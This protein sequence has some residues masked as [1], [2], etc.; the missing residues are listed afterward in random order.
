MAMTEQQA[1]LPKRINFLI[2]GQEATALPGES[3]IAAADRIGV[4]IPRFCYHEKLSVVANCRQCLVE[5][6]GAPKTLPACATKVTEGMEVYTRSMAARSSQKAIMEFL[7][8]NHPLDCPICDQGGEC[9]LQD[10]AMGFGHG[11]SRFSEKKRAVIDQDLGPLVDTHMTRCIHCTRCI[12]FSDELAGQPELAMLSRGED[13]YVGTVLNKGL[14]SELSGNVI[15]VCPVGA[16]T[17]KPFQY[18]GRSWAFKQHAFASMHDCLGSHIYYQTLAKGYEGRSTIMR[19]LPKRNDLVNEVWLADRDRFSYQGLTSKE[20]L[21]QPMLKKNGVFQAV[22]WDEALKVMVDQMKTQDPSQA[23]VL[24]SPSTS[25]E[26]GFA[27]KQLLSQW[28]CD[29]VDHRLQSVECLKANSGVFATKAHGQ[30]SDWSEVRCGLLLGSHLRHEQPMAAYWL[31][32]A[33][34][35]GGRLFAANPINY[36]WSFE[37]AGQSTVLGHEMMGWMSLAVNVLCER[38]KKPRPSHLKVNPLESKSIRATVDAFVDAWCA[39]PERGLIVL[40]AYALS[41]DEASNLIALVEL[42][43]TLAEGGQWVGMWPGANALGLTALGLLP[44]ASSK[45]SQQHKHGNADDQGRWYWCHQVEPEFDCAQGQ[46]MIDR[47]KKADFVVVSTSY[48]SAQHLAYADC[49]LPSCLPVEADGSLM[50]SFGHQ[51]MNHAILRPEGQSKPLWLMAQLIGQR[52]GFTAVTE[53]SFEALVAACDQALST[54]SDVTHTEAINQ[55]SSITNITES[56]HKPIETNQLYRVGGPWIYGIDG[57]VR[58]AQALQAMAE[59]MQVAAAHIHP[60]TA[61][62]FNLE[63]GQL[64]SFSQGSSKVSLPVVLNTTVHQQGVWIASGHQ[65]TSALIDV[66][67]LISVMGEV[68]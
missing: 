31:R 35:Q 6:K 60:E 33:S 58:R 67:G 12:R 65:S 13:A 20:R 61:A 8:I 46:A 16:L 48:Q 45:D 40:G 2:N 29:W 25:L 49:L 17:S 43:V 30:L 21:S 28:G 15:D 14:T 39:A 56:E 68:N 44:K 59:T 36:D 37:L 57:V 24:V 19:A 66:Y 62:K 22:S 7:L 41:I 5:V 47:L 4:Y 38:M 9:E 18:T 50:N 63:S 26:D 27:L 11:I 42:F 10:T 32:K 64:A 55:S 52:L 23:R 51:Y 3:V 1:S 54:I 53:H 34:L